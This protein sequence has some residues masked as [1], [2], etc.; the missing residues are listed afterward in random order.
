MQH[1]EELGALTLTLDVS[2]PESEIQ[3]VVDEAINAYGAIDILFNNAGVAL[4]GQ[5]E[6]VRNKSL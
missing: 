2:S 6:E 4:Q 3:K 1:L 5:V